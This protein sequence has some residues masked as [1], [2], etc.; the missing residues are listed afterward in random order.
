MPAPVTPTTPTLYDINQSLDVLEGG[1]VGEEKAR[2][3]VFTNF[4]IGAKPIILRGSR[5][6]GKSHTM[7]VLAKYCRKPITISTSSEKVHSRMAELN[8]FS[9]F[10]IPEILDRQLGASQF[11]ELVGRKKGFHESYYSTF[12]KSVKTL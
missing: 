4:V 9:H 8:S 5:A 1:I 3:V 2:M 12:S 10:I 7:K 6:S 11:G